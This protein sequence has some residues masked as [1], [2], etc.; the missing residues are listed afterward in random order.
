M[1]TVADKW[2]NE[3]SLAQHVKDMTAEEMEKAKK[4]FIA[5]MSKKK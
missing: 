3:W 5:E 4:A 1:G 2:G